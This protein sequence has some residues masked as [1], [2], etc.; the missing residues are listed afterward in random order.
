MAEHV[1]AHPG[2]PGVDKGKKPEKRSLHPLV[3][4]AQAAM[5]I[6]AAAEGA[7]MVNSYLQY[8]D[9]GHTVTA[10]VAGDIGKD[11]GDFFGK[12]TNNI[13]TQNPGV[14]FTGTPTETGTPIKTSTP[15][16]TPKPTDTQQPSETPKPLIDTITFKTTD[17]KDVT[18]PE[19]SGPTAATEALAYVSENSKWVNGNLMTTDWGRFNPQ[20]D[21]VAKTLKKIPGYQPRIGGPFV[22]YAP[23][24]SYIKIEDLCLG[25]GTVIIFQD[26]DVNI[27]IIY[28]DN[29]DAADLNNKLQNGII[30]IPTPV[31]P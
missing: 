12:A 18:M 22:E 24:G 27:K 26:K 5:V 3:R 4:L 2:L 14:T 20:L 23:D 25:T 17:G 31:T 11:V 8:G 19:F 21:E 30:K 10:K 1:P 13:E 28:L 29:V 15:T 16:D 7:D 6:T 9:V